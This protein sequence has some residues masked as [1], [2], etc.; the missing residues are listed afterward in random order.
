[1][2]VTIERIGTDVCALTGKQGDGVYC[3]FADG[4]FHGFLLWKSLRQLLSLKQA[5]QQGEKVKP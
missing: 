5:Q 3:R 1:M 4:S 2:M